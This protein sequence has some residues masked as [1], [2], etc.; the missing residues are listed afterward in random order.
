MTN[1]SEEKTYKIITKDLEQFLSL[2][3]PHIFT[4]EQIDRQFNIQTREA[5]GYRWHALENLVKANRL[6]KVA[7][8]KYRLV[9]SKLEILDWQD[10]DVED[11]VKVLWPLN[12]HKYVKTYHKSIN[13]IA[14]APGAGKTAACYDFILRNMGHPMGIVLFTNDMTAEEIKERMDNSEMEIPY[15][16]PFPIY[17]RADNFGDVIEPDKINVIDYLDLNSEVY[18]IGDEIEKIYRKLNRGIAVIAIQK[19][20]GQDIGIGGLYSWKRAK[21][22]CS[23]DSIKEGNEYLHKLVIVKARGRIDPKVNPLSVLIKFS[24]VNGIKFIPRGVADS[25]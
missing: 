25:T 23:L 5:K 22:Y 16:A 11:T 2:V 7:T 4:S 14:G 1:I 24:L 20:P 19:K 17:D 3:G 13:I 6:Q 12:L 9:D 10:A 8:N 18:L 21:F 15:P